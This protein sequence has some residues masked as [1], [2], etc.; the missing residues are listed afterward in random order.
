MSAFGVAALR[1]VRAR[2]ALLALLF[3]ACLPIAVAVASRGHGAYGPLANVVGSWSLPFLAFTVTGALGERGDLAR[4]VQQLA[5]TGI[6]RTKASVAH[7]AVAVIASA[8][9]AAVVAPLTALLAHGPSDP[10]T[11]SDAFTAMW[12]AL[13]GGAAYAGAFCLGATFA[14]GAGRS[15]VLAID[16]LFAGTGALAAFFP[17]SHVHALFGGPAV[18]GLRGAASAACLVG[19]ALVTA[20]LAIARTRRIPR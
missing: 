2:R 19:L 17:R 7:V 3:W 14:K 20:S 4:S 18:L 10:P 16:W 5:F 6:A 1:L 11:T 9:L 13:F 15:A 12:I 8:L